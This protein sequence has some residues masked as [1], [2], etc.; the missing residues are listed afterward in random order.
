MSHGS[1][2]L[3][4]CY[5]HSKI[6]STMA[7]SKVVSMLLAFMFL[8][9]QI[10]TQVQI[11]KMCKWNKRSPKGVKASSERTSSRATKCSSFRTCSM[12]MVSSGRNFSEVPPPPNP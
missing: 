9:I 4:A 10:E 3:Q 6:L 11:N 7:N 12:H 8:I 2:Y 5:A 1:T